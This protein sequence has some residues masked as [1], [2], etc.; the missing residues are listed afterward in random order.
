MPTDA[1]LEFS[2]GRISKQRAIAALG[3]RD[4]AQ[5]LLALGERG[6]TPPRLPENQIAA[7]QHIF[8]GLLREARHEHPLHPRRS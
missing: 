4:Y 1:L 3:L 8:V 2:Q 5:L 6:L 7:M